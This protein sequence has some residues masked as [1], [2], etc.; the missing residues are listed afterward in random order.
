VDGRPVLVG[1]PALLEEEGLDLEPFAAL[2]Q[3]MA[4]Q[5]QTVSAVAE[6]GRVIGLIG[7]ADSL[8]PEAEQV[9]AQIKGMGIE[10]AMVTGDNEQTAQ[11]VA[12][13]VGIERVHAGVTPDRKE[14]TVAQELERT[15]GVVVMV[16]DGI[17]DA[18]ALAR[19]TVGIAIGTGADVAMQA[20]Q[21]TLT[22][23]DLSG[24]VRAL[25]LGKITLRHVK[26]NLGFAFGYNVAAVPLAA[27]GYLSPAIAAGAMA[28]S[29]VSVVTN[30]LRLR[31]ASL[32]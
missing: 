30:S 21:V 5:G 11:A 28:A 16:G 1:A 26:Q 3:E 24:V 22:G 31:G 18:P 8:R 4:G 20:G 15:G 17:N 2:R 14:E 9:V 29:S 27:L 10:V 12:R 19:A 32:D 6:G 13:R 7:L 23:S 25:R